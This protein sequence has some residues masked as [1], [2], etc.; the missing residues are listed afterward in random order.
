M[1]SIGY[2]RAKIEEERKNSTPIQFQDFSDVAVANALVEEEQS[3]LRRRKIDRMPN[4]F[5]GFIK[6]QLT[7]LI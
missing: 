7:H 1:E 5:V 4:L 6:K 2:D 3:K